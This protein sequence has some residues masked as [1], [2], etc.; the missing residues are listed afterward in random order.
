MFEWLVIYFKNFVRT[1]Q[2]TLTNDWIR[3]NGPWRQPIG[4]LIWN[5]V[6]FDILEAQVNWAPSKI[7]ILATAGPLCV[8]C[9]RLLV[10]KRVLLP[11]EARWIQNIGLSK[12]ASSKFCAKICCT[13]KSWSERKQPLLSLDT[14]V[15]ILKLTLLFRRNFNGISE[16]S[17]R[18]F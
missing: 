6:Y 7:F 11:G 9:L 1:N 8:P 16:R 14:W 13:V 5:E 15:S 10:S 2:S 12:I 3:T 17:F 18:T 4:I